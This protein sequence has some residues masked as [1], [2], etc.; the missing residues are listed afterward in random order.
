M[1]AIHAAHKVV[2]SQRSTTV[3]MAAP[4]L[5]TQQTTPV[6]ANGPQPPASGAAWR[7]RL[8]AAL[9]TRRAHLTHLCVILADVAVN[10]AGLLLA[11]FTCRTER[12]ASAV[13]VA[14]SAL[15]WT[16][17]AL[18]C[19]ML[20]ELLSRA[21]AVGPLRLFRSSVQ[22]LDA[23]VLVGLLAVEAAVSDRAAEEALGL[24]VVVRLAR[25]V[26][27]LSSLQEYDSD[28]RR[29]VEARA[30]AAEKRAAAAEAALRQLRARIDGPSPRQCYE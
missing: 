12:K 19:A 16:S 10:V 4:V 30:D 2:S 25:V 13:H 23:A 1:Y 5:P 8:F 28:R 22:T 26:H 9:H 27:L 11:L 7:H 20:L 14:E 29:A 6:L 21:I 15:R 24:L 3:R 18:L 17:V